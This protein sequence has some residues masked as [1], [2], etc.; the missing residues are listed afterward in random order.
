M[1][2]SYFFWDCGFCV[3]MVSAIFCMGAC[4]AGERYFDEI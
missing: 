1:C 4:R 2:G 3:G